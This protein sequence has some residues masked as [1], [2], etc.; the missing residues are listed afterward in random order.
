MKAGLAKIAIVSAVIAL[1]LLPLMQPKNVWAGY[2]SIGSHFYKNSVYE[3]HYAES[4]NGVGKP[5][6]YV[7]TLYD[8]VP[9]IEVSDLR[10]E[11]NGERICNLTEEIKVE[12]NTLISSYDHGLLV[13]KVEPSEEG[14]SVSY[15]VRGEANLTLTLWRWYY[16]SVENVTAYSPSGSKLKP[17]DTINFTFQYYGKE[18]AGEIFFNPKPDELIVYKD[19][20]GVNKILAS[21]NRIENVSLTVKASRK[22]ENVF[23]PSSYLVYP[24]IAA[25]IS[26]A[27]LFLQPFKT[28]F[29]LKYISGDASS[30]S[31]KPIHLAIIAFSVRA[32]LAPFFM[33]AWDV[34]TLHE[35]LEDFMSGRNVYASV[36]EKTMMLRQM[37]GVEASYE[38]YAY[39]PHAILFYLPSYL[40]YKL[41]C[42]GPAI[43]GGHFQPLQLIEPNIYIFLTLTK[44]PIML[45]DA[46]IT[47]VLAKRSSGLGLLYALLPY[48]IA[49]TS[50]WGNFDSLIGLLL[51]LAFL[52]R[53]EHPTA[54]GILYGISLTKLFVIVTFPAFI[55]SMRRERSSILK[56]MLGLIL[57]QAPTIA[58]FIQDPNSMLNV[59]LFHSTRSP[60]GVNIYNL[61]P[62]LYSYQLQSTLNRIS[63]AV[64]GLT[65]LVCLIKGKTDAEKI[66]FSLAAY[67]AVGPVV[68][69][70]HLATLIPLLLLQGYSSLTLS[71]STGYLAY[72]LLY[73]GPTY[74]MA[75]LEKILGEDAMS[76]LSSS[77]TGLF[78]QITPQ[79]LYT[80][81]V[82]CSLAVLFTIA[83]ACTSKHSQ[84]FRRLKLEP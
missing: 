5:Q 73:S 54:S 55:L 16:D 66:V 50:V 42:N 18:C 58:F 8:R 72:A 10:S 11:L 36:A 67:M 70:Q 81:A 75:P 9:L 32:A 49:I 33:H 41:L 45:A 14:V 63:T 57:S 44:V 76:G 7:L 27:F 83:E 48:S 19:D 43:V 78:N 61:A 29:K 52:T 28:R 47:Y 82:A 17:S 2:G 30:L 3:I 56:F 71:L 25:F 24:C 21:F 46:A 77:W 20:V 15:S 84:S 64:L 53:K 40:A 79:L 23:T 62:K 68:N 38:G 69:E 51:L 59:L 31:L 80:I 39:L 34:T 1:S 65:V 4:G 60:G 35:A 22:P 74:F 6:V 13:K 12:G 37:N 26:G